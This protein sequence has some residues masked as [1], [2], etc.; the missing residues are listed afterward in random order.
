MTFF[1][2]GFGVGVAGMGVGA[3]FFFPNTRDQKPSFFGTGV[4]TG[5]GAALP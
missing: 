3:G 1:F 2:T 4:A 5:T